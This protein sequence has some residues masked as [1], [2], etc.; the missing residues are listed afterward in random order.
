MLLPMTLVGH[1]PL[2]VVNNA[3]TARDLLRFYGELLHVLREGRRLTLWE[4]REHLSEGSGRFVAGGKTGRMWRALSLL[5]VLQ[6]FRLVAVE[7]KGW[8]KDG[9]ELR[10]TGLLEVLPRKPGPMSFEEYAAAV[11]WGYFAKERYMTGKVVSRAL[12]DRPGEVS[13]IG[14]PENP[15]AYD[16]VLSDSYVE[17]ARL[18]PKSVSSAHTR[19]GY[20][21]LLRPL[22]D[23]ALLLTLACVSGYVLL[24]ARPAGTLSE[25]YTGGKAPRMLR[26]LLRNV[27]GKDFAEPR[28]FKSAVDER[29]GPPKESSQWQRLAYEV[30]TGF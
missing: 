6:A 16:K 25:Y 13:P 20:A 8:R 27:L 19:A 10:G 2:V 26:K 12:R 29:S 4:L 23:A 1:E 28:S 17:T 11:L 7:F 5:R 24:S 21:Y 18:W 9:V 14:L 30:A 15:S 22:S 3:Q